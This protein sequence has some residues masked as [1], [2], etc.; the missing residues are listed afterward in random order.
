[1]ARLPKLTRMIED[2]E[3][4]EW[5][6]IKQKKNLEQWPELRPLQDRLLSIGGD[7]V[8]LEPECDL[9]A[10]L[11]EGRI[12]EGKV[13]LKSMEKCK[14]HSNCA[15]LWSKNPKNNRIAT[16]WALSDD[17]IWRQHTWIH[18][19]KTIIE[20]TEPRTLYFG[21]VLRDEEANNFWRVHYS[22]YNRMHLF[23]C[24]IESQTLL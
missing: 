21:M 24:Q 12:I 20:T 1:M 13:I 4:V 10:L 15:K 3:W 7:W 16:G 19:G 9:E 22:H 14:C 8:A 23:A 2:P 5:A 18:K 6:K 11:K 17:G